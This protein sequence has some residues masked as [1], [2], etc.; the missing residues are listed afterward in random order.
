[1]H[2]F[3]ELVGAL[4]VC[5]VLMLI[6]VMVAA[7]IGEAIAGLAELERRREALGLGRRALMRTP[8]DVRPRRGSPGRRYF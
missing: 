4:V 1:M 5:L 8:T 3:F 6:A 7:S 2:I